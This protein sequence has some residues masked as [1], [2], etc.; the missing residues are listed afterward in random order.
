MAKK[1]KPKKTVE[2]MK[3]EFPSEYKMLVFLVNKILE[4]HNMF[5]VMAKEGFKKI[6]TFEACE[7]LIDKGFLKIHADKMVGGYRCWFAV[8]NPILEEY[9][10]I[11]KYPE[12]E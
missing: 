1:E 5:N 11:G 6:D 10:P 9:I 2:E 7:E 3:K 12:G 8:W 4:N